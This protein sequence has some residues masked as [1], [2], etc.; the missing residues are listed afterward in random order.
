ME[1]AAMKSR[2]TTAH[3]E[4]PAYQGTGTMLSNSGRSNG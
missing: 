1:S 2:A 3:V 4:V